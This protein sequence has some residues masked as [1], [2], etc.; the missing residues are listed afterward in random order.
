M[1]AKCLFQGHTET[2]DLGWP[3]CQC[4]IFIKTLYEFHKVRNGLDL[5]DMYSYT[6]DSTILPN[7][8]Q[9]SIE[10]TTL[11]SN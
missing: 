3:G 4:G 2:A 7:F 1:G 11:T 10:T 5:F 6:L 8:P 9:K